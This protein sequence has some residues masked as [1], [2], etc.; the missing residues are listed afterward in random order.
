MP[1]ISKYLTLSV[2]LFVF[3]FAFFASLSLCNH[4]TDT[5]INKFQ[6]NNNKNLARNFES[7]IWC[8][9]I[10]SFRILYTK[11]MFN[12]DQE[13]I[14]TNFSKVAN[15]VLTSS[16]AY[17]I[18]LF[19]DAEQSFFSSNDLDILLPKAKSFDQIS[20]LLDSK[21]DE[22]HEIIINAE[23]KNGNNISKFD[24]VRSF[25]NL[26]SKN[27]PN[28][29]INEPEIKARM[30]I[31]SR[32][33]QIKENI[34]IIKY[35]VFS[36][37]I[38]F[39]FLLYLFMYF[40]NRHAAQIIN[41]QHEEKLSLEKAKTAAE[42]DNQEKSM[43]LANISHELRTPLNAIIGFSEIIKEEVMGSLGHP[44]YKEYIIDI[45]SSGVHLLSLINDILDYSKAEAHKL[46]VEKIEVDI[47]K[48]SHTCIRFVEPRATQAKVILEEKLPENHVIL[49]CDPKRIKQ[50]ILN[51]LSNAVKFTPENGKVSLSVITST[52]EEYVKIIVS[53]TGIG[54]A[55][56]DISKAMSP[57]GQID[58][59]I[60]RKYEGTGLGLPLT[61]TLTEIMGGKFE[62]DS[63]VGLG[64]TITL[65]F[66]LNKPS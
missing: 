31:M 17:Q 23:T 33:E 47:N 25:I 45:N 4:I 19:K 46:E 40:T 38:I 36:G 41:K 12:W 62:I 22:F 64:T 7:N 20:K 3:I 60:S 57:F 56:K 54:I 29:N 48:I 28:A 8:R 66:S 55:P 9:Y 44:Q 63:Q 37:I 5:F 58:S 32:T 27:C 16:H 21:Q 53:D 13:P 2:F 6:G 59:S 50:I 11:N 1:P 49:Y 52:I 39:F 15:T 43:F 10:P 42:F 18:A 61:K 65:T 35:L 34:N 30:M 14:F 26:S 24:V 51:L